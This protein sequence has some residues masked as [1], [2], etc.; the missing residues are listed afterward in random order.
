MIKRHRILV[1]AASLV[2]ASATLS[3]RAEQPTTQPSDYT[4][5][6]KALRERLDQLEVRQKEADQKRVEAEQKLEAQKTE[7]AVKADAQHHDNLFD[8][9]G[10]TGGYI[11]DRFTIQSDDGRFVL[12]PW[13]QLQIRYVT[14]WRQ[15]FKP[16]GGDDTQ[17]GFEIR[18]M[19][20]GLDGNMFSPD[21]TYFF[22]WATNRANGTS[23]VKSSTGATV[24]TVSNGLGG[25]PILEEAWVKYKFHN[26]DFYVQAGQLKDPVLHDQIVSSRY[27]QSAERSL[28][29]DIFT[30]GDA[31]TEGIM[32]IYD[33]KGWIR[34]VAGFNHGMRSANTNFQDFPTNAYNWGVAGRAEVKVMGEWKDYSQ[35]GAVGVKQPLLVFGA[36]AD[37]SERGPANQT[38][39][40]IDGQFAGASG[41]NMYGAYVGR[42]T[43]HNFGIP[44]TSSTGASFA[45]PN[46]NDAGKATYENSG[47]IQVGWLFNQHLEPFG[48][49]EYMTLRG[50][51][52]GSIDNDIP[53]ITT[54]LNYYFFGHRAKLTA[55]VIY[56]PQ[57]IPI[58]DQGGDLLISNGKAEI[59]G[60]LQFQLLI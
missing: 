46:L 6:I 54:G 2:V 55:E 14:L 7:S 42:Y 16:D 48:R 41:F 15:D 11:N 18:R 40:A 39:F 47:L 52:Q 9:G 50:T 26:T 53:V 34:T 32:G 56:L 45:T 33:P 20:I 35:V 29:A 58:D 37:Y 30:N 60:V 10:I 23:T 4:Q 25:V 59:S 51:P 38:V 24:G 28:T 44:L 3:V 27:Q 36:G 31:F 19:K 12:R 43:N 1:A 8:A 57:G 22:N 17:T 21:F 49:F 13:Y 5:E